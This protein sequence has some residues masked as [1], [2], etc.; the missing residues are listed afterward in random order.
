MGQVH[1]GSATTTAAVRRAIQHS[2]ESLRALAKRYGIN[3]KTAAKWKKQTSVADLPTGPR[4]PTSTVLSIEEEAIIIAFRRHTLLPL[5]DCLY[6]LQATI[7]HLTRSSLHRCLQ[8]HGISRLPEVEGD[9]EPKRRFKS[10]PI[11]FFHIDIAEV[12]T[13][14]GKL[15][16]YV[17][18]DRTRK[19]ALVQVVKKTGRG[20]AYAFQIAT[21][22]A[23]PYRT[24]TVLPTTAFSS[25]SRRA[26]PPG[27]RPDTSRTCST[28]VVANTASTTADQGEA[29]PCANRRSNE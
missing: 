10:Y 2:Q 20:S 14:E 12:Q 17:A 6:A 9:K 3:Q 21:I 24:H 1:H 13:A 18:I 11:G 26:G 7:P 28:C 25:P 23:V 19:F 29:Y 5:D 15:Y 8:R 22:E 4:E 16:L 27:P